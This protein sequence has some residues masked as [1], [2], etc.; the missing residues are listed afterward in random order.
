MYM[1][2]IFVSILFCNEYNI[3]CLAIWKRKSLFIYYDF[4]IAHLLIFYVI[5]AEKKN[6]ENALNNDV[7]ITTNPEPIKGPPTISP[8]QPPDNVIIDESALSWRRTNPRPN[9]QSF[10]KYFILVLN[11]MFRTVYLKVDN[12]AIFSIKH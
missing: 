6:R 1:Q 4:V 7:Q 3:L 10:S 2:V 8:K 12:Y 11:Q 9:S 5:I